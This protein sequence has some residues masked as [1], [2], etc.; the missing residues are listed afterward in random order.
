MW[1]NLWNKIKGLK[2]KNVKTLLPAIVAFVVFVAALWNYPI[3]AVHLS[4]NLTLIVHYAFVIVGA[5]GS[6]IGILSSHKKK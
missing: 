1:K 2:E 6:L 5:V 3:D 4:D